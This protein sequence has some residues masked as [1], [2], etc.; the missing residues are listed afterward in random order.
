MKLTCRTF[1]ASTVGLAASL[2]VLHSG[3]ALAGPE[4]DY[5]E[6]AKNYAVNDLVT[7]MPLLRKAAAA[8]HAAAQAMLGEISDLSDADEEAVEYFQKSAAQGNVD[9]QFGLGNMLA[10]G[11]GIAKNLGEAHKWILRA[12]EQGHKTAINVLA[13]AYIGGGLN[14]PESDRQGAEALRWIRAAADNGYLVAME[15]LMVAYR[16]GELG[17]VANTGEAEQWAEKIRKLKGLP[18][19]EKRRNKRGNQK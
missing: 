9:G 2:V 12:A 14:I 18:K 13:G 3:Q 16:A 17:L 10:N 7:A 19:G 1:L 15:K 11:E 4:E 6:G 8:G 5:A